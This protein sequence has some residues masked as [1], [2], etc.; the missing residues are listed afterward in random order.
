MQRAPSIL[1]VV[2]FVLMLTGQAQ[3]ADPASQV[4]IEINTKADYL[5]VMSMPLDRIYYGEDHIDVLIPAD[6]L[7]ELDKVGLSY[8]VIHPDI[9]SFYQSRLTAKE[10]RNGSMGGYRT[11]SEIELVMDSIATENPL[12]VQ[13]R[14][15]IGQTHQGRDIWVMKISDDVL[16]DE[17]E[18]EIYYNAAIHAREVITPEILVYFMRYLTDNYGSD[19]EVTYLVDNREM[20]FTLCVNPD[21][22]YYNEL[23]D[24]GGGGYWRKNR[25]NNGD[26]TWGVDLN[27]NFGYEWGY[28]DNGSS[29]YPGDA[30]YRGPS[31]F[32]EPESQTIRD[33]TNSRN[34]KIT[35]TY[36]SYSNLILWPWGYDYF[37]TPDED[38]FSEMGDSVVAFNGY[39][40]GPA[41][42]LYPANGVTDDWFYGADLMHPKIYAFTPEV[43]GSSDGFWPPT[44]RITDLVS[45]NLGPN[46][47]WAR[48]CENPEQ[49][50]APATPEIYAVADVDTSFFDLYWHHYDALNPAV[51]FDVWQ[52]QGLE[53]V[54]D[55]LEGPVSYWD[56]DGFVLS[57][58]RYHSSSHSYWSDNN[59]GSDY[60][61]TAT[62]PITVSAGDTSSF[63]T[64]YDIETDWDYAY[65]EVSTDGVAWNDIPG[66]ITTTSDPHG[67]NLGNGIT[68]SSGGWTEA[69][70]DLSAYGGEQVW[71]RFRYRT[72][73]YVIEEGFYVDDI[74]PL[75]VFGNALQLADNQLDT[76]LHVTGLT[77]GEYF[78]QVFAIDEQDQMSAGSELEQVTVSFDAPCTWLVG[79]ADGNGDWNV[80][81]VVYLLS[82]IFADGAAPLNDP[83]GS[84]DADC[85]GNVNV[86]DAVALISY[87]FADGAEPGAECGC[88]NY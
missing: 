30:T 64:W 52:Y 38:I 40:P 88:E 3:A 78:Y 63:W 10:T 67:N 12:I 65:V 75:D 55:D 26:G 46:L 42:T 2:L 37:L 76:T 19:P 9:T 69:Y 85:S 61:L 31:A 49:L 77:E 74:Y 24:P 50:R 41:H 36:H 25:R 48:I 44:Y 20:F 32:S 8:S 83:I 4:R 84:G 15:S 53:R 73:S 82:Y 87:V 17:D 29:P 80:A 51:G 86:T 60:K 13:P 35:V 66:S 34:F 71:L 21:G 47:F 16:V 56:D 28:D 14:W 5:Q 22:Y 11:L 81:D 39:A 6:E 58:S 45:E 1:V 79:D 43:G 33:F 62:Q 27:R 70:F 54:T 7:G 68:G 57:T 72:D 18:P 59:N 23:T